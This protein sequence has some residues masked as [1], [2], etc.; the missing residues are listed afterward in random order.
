M[1]GGSASATAGWVQEAELREGPGCGVGIEVLHWDSE[2]VVAAL[3]G[4]VEEPGVHHAGISIC[5]V[6]LP[7][8]IGF[9]ELLEDSALGQA[10]GVGI[11]G[12]II[13][14]MAG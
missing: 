7:G 14:A 9:R 12:F 10:M 8:M 3:E 2:L 1:H 11:K 5:V 13:S 6:V 4:P